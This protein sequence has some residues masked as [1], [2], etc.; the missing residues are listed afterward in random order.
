MYFASDIASG[1]G[2]YLN[3]LRNLIR[4]FNMDNILVTDD[5]EYSTKDQ[6]IAFLKAY[7]FKYIEDDLKPN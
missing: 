5:K 4:L 6:L 2:A 7:G 3:K 1:H